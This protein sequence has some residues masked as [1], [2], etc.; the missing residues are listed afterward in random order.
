[1]GNHNLPMAQIEAESLQR[2]FRRMSERDKGIVF[3]LLVSDQGLTKETTIGLTTGVVLQ[4]FAGSKIHALTNKK[5]MHEK[6]DSIIKDFKTEGRADEVPAMYM[7]TQGKAPTVDGSRLWLHDVY[8]L[9][10]MGFLNLLMSLV[11][12]RG[13]SSVTTLKHDVIRCIRFAERVVISLKQR[14]YSGELL[15]LFVDFK[16][17]LR[18]NSGERMMSLQTDLTY[19]DGQELRGKTADREGFVDNYAPSSDNL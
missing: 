11:S 13:E 12:T 15:E 4:L 18:G 6:I 17:G 2:E 3:S 1:M 7:L 19:V 9:N 14:D 16:G 10:D 8:A 5:A